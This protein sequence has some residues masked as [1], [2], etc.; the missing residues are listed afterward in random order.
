[1]PAW[2]RVE[3]DA[4]VIAALILA[5]GLA[6]PSAG[7]VRVP[8]SAGAWGGVR[9]RPEPVASY[10]I[11]AALDPVRHTIE[12]RERLSW[13][14]RSAEPI[15]EMYVHLYLNAFEGPGS[16]FALERER[17]RTGRFRLEAAEPKRGEW[18]FIEL[19]SVTQSG[20]AVPWTFVHPDSGPE[21]DHTVVRLDLPRAVP[22]GVS[23]VLEIAFHSQLPRVVARTGWSG[24][25]HLAAQF[26]P[27]VGVLELPGERGA[28]APRWNCHE[29][30]LYSEFYADFGGYRAAIT[31]PR[32]STFGSVGMQ[33]AP[34][35]ETAAGVVYRVAQDDVHDFA[36]T[37]WD[38]FA[39]PLEGEWNGVRIRVLHPPE[40]EK[41]ARIALQA[42][43]DTLEYFGRTLGP[44]PY[45]Q[46]TVVVPPYGALESGGMEYETF[47]TTIGALGPPLL[48][49]VRFVTVHELGHGWF[50]G[51]LANNEFE[52]PFLD[53]GLDE[54]WNARML[55]GEGV[56][57]KAPGL[58][59]ALG[60]QTPQLSYFE[61]ERNGTTR[62][63]PDP[64]A[65]NAWDR[66][67]RGSYGLVYSRSALVFHD[68]E[69]R[70]GGD[71][72]ARGFAEYY[73]RWKFRHPSTADL[74]AALAE[75]GRETVRQW[76]AAQVYAAA[77]VDDR[78]ESI[79]T[80]ELVPRP[81]LV[82]EVDGGRVE[83]DSS[84]A[85]EQE[86]AARAAFHAAHPE[87]KAEG[88]G[89]FPWRSTVRLRR[90]GAQVPQAVSIRFDDGTTELVRWPAE[91]RWHR[92]V[93]DRPSRV[94]SVQIDPLREVLLDL[95]KLDDG[96]TREGTPAASARWTLE[97]QAWA[98]LLLALL[99]SL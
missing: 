44:Y 67:S 98:G 31:V 79:E 66:W 64:I 30:H 83:L 14:N 68:L 63:P 50:M 95:N 40:Y 41:A 36:F 16:T 5:A 51:L 77:P 56:R 9:E 59:G 75:V 33:T 21:T 86:S 43:R 47:F 54:F 58:L 53:E 8:S 90:Y 6:G 85:R 70:L 10:E 2:A 28:T 26:F 15:R 62:F 49:F 99:G 25:Y 32:G 12:G 87:A 69:R 61:L 57:I 84:G 71:A 92:W 72:L 93:F 88:P 23:A 4:R 11:E 45:R 97:V 35:E 7:A 60:L 42:S 17:E 38:G 3:Y 46:I 13:R 24:S 39:P 82:L 48:P 74:E 37:A 19:K 65:G 78:V 94:A 55:D 76:F 52:E 91:E 96:R 73:R 34:P 80:V 27:K 1:M 20:H 29:F 18:G 81:G 89:P 22:P